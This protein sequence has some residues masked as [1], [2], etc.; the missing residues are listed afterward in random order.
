MFKLI[1]TTTLSSK[2]IR[3]QDGLLGTSVIK[4]AGKG[5][6]KVPLPMKQQ[7]PVKGV[8]PPP[9]PTLTPYNRA[10]DFLAFNHAS[11]QP[12]L[13]K[14]IV[15]CVFQNFQNKSGKRPHLDLTVCNITQTL[16]T[17]EPSPLVRQFLPPS[18]RCLR[19]S[20]RIQVT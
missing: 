6:G 11:S 7:P 4:R 3:C 15:S 18:F 8:F 2:F 14:L 5:L 1:V 19:Q 17:L 13:C 16:L 20:P 12:L 10:G 9:P